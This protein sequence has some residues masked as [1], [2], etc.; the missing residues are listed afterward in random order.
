MHLLFFKETVT[1]DNEFAIQLVQDRF[2]NM[3][4]SLMVLPSTTLCI[5]ILV[6][7]QYNVHTLQ[8]LP[9]V[10]PCSECMYMH[11]SLSK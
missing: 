7:K 2:W 10:M 6:S 9:F 3:L 11:P 5:S 8:E 4:R 1:N